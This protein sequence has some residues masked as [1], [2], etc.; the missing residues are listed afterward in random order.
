MKNGCLLS[1]HVLLLKVLWG[2][3]TGLGVKVFGIWFHS[4]LAVMMYI[5]LVGSL[6]SLDSK[7]ELNV[8]VLI[9]TQKF[10]PCYNYAV[11]MKPKVRKAHGQAST[12]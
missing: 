11:H 6:A 10:Y 8:H 4:V 7:T 5:T 12:L 3:S 9:P 1:S 2:K